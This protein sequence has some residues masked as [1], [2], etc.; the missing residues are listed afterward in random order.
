MIDYRK[1]EVIKYIRTMI[2]MN[3]VDPL[4]AVE[5]AS[6]TYIIPP[7]EQLEFERR[8]RQKYLSNKVCS[9]YEQQDNTNGTIVN[10]KG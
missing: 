9:L 5:Y 7:L 1:N 2:E 10:E 6:H 3:G 8:I 4:K